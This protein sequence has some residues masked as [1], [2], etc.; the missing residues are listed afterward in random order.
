M[1]TTATAVDLSKKIPPRYFLL[2]ALACV[3]F[4]GQST[5]IKFLN[6]QL[7]PIQITF[8]PFYTGTLLMIPLL[9]RSRHLNPNAARVRWK[10]WRMFLIAGILGQVVT[11][12]GYVAGVTRSLA[13]NAAILGLLLPVISSIMA[14]VMLRERLTKLRL[15]A[16][17]I[18]L[19]GVL[20]LSTESLK[21]SSFLD[22]RYLEGNLL[23]ILANLG[24][25]F[26]NVY[27]KSLFKKFQQIEVVAF[28]FV[29]ASLASLPLVIWLEPFRLHVVQVFTWQTWLAFAYQ[30]IIAYNIA[31]LIFFIALKHLDV[32]VVS[33]TLY[34][35][36]VFGIII[37]AVFLHERLSAMA[38]CGAAVVLLSSTL[39]AKYDRS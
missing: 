38:V 24:S 30:G 9:V 37:A 31:M 12:W 3:M 39:V 33:L 21:R 27:C 1:G 10:D 29:T 34:M 22:M 11:Q 4:A 20:F 23:I 17:G 32:T 2:L 14:S 8:F 6:R 18:G 5:A 35:I 28:T 26:Y 19:L 25:A 16:L 15:A 36:P 7:P 13:S